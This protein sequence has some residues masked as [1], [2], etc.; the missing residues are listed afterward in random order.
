MTLAEANRAHAAVLAA[1]VTA[2]SR[3]AL[4]TRIAA[5]LAANPRPR[6]DRET[7]AAVAEPVPGPPPKRAATSSRW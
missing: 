1:P 7:K 6:D 2:P 4:T 3:R 5:D